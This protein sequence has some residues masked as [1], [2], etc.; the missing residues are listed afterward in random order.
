LR[1]RRNTRAYLQTLLRGV[2]ET[3]GS[4]I[5]FCRIAEGKAD[6][7]PRLAPT[8]DWDVAAGHA[9]VRAAGGTVTAPDATPLVYGTPDLLIP[10]FVATG[11]PRMIKAVL[12]KQGP[13]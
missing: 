8:R 2:T 12:A 7:Y 3:C 1:Q 6:L 11:D 13:D 9:I 5:K 10:Q 4:S